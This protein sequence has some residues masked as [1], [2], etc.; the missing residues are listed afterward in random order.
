MQ[1][2][3]ADFPYFDLISHA[4]CGPASRERL[5]PAQIAQVARTEYSAEDDQ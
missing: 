3:D 5:M 1:S 4:R 2:Q